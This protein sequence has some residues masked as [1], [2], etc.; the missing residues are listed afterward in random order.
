MHPMPLPTIIEK[1]QNPA[2]I[3]SQGS[4]SN[5]II[6]VQTP[7]QLLCTICQTIIIPT[8]KLPHQPPVQSTDL[9]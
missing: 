8:A 5:V 1:H 3:S 6:I 7:S 2:I 9:I 4:N